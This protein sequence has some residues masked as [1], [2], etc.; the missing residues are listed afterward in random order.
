MIK[1]ETMQSILARRSFKGFKND[2]IPEDVLETIIEAGKYA[3]T[4]RN[5]QP[6]HFTVVKTEEGKKLFKD[7]LE[8]IMAGRPTP[9]AQPSNIVSKPEAEMRGAPV[10]IIVSYDTSIATALYDGVLAMG[11]MMNAAA[12]F[13]VMSGW[14]H[15]VLRDFTTPELKAMFKI[16]EGYEI[17]A[18]AF[19]GYGDGEPKDRG[20]RKEGTVTIL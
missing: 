19:F 17:C 12:S 10:L 9:P 4:G 6:W 18:A 14:T 11:N 8:K 13:N 2:A 3:P 5:A 16:P 15:T 20:P 1:N 7:E